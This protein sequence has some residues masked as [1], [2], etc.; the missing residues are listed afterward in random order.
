MNWQRPLGKHYALPEP[1][2]SIA[3][4]QRRHGTTEEQIR[5]MMFPR[6]ID[7]LGGIEALLDRAI[8]ILQDR[9]P[10]QP[11]TDERVSFEALT[12]IEEKVKQMVTK[13][14]KEHFENAVA[15]GRL[16]PYVTESGE[17]VYRSTTNSKE[18]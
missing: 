5:G 12:I 2:R 8:D 3:R 9:E 7:E 14:V 11:M 13:H 18:K 1:W 10:D 17:I 15:E 4:H 6:A 16:D